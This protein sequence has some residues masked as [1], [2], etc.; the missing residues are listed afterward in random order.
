MGD[1][2]SGCH[3]SQ[4]KR[5][6]QTATSLTSQTEQSIVV[7]A[8][9]TVSLHNFLSYLLP[10]SS[11]IVLILSASTAWR[12]L[13]GLAPITTPSATL[14]GP[15]NKVACILQMPRPIL[16]TPKLEKH[17]KDQPVASDMQCG[18]GP[19]V[20]ISSSCSCDYVGQRKT[21]A[22]PPGGTTLSNYP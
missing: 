15:R 5:T 18:D 13:R 10:I 11:I 16:S 20:V 8:T 6:Q 1:P 12:Y 14:M 17:S 21:S 4:G 19:Q 2:N 9:R 3:R 7:I 22:T